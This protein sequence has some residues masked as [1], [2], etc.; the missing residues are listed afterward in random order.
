MHAPSMLSFLV[1][2]ILQTSTPPLVQM[3]TKPAASSSADRPVEKFALSSD[4]HEVEAPVTPKLEPSLLSIVLESCSIKSHESLKD[5]AASSTTTADDHV[6]EHGRTATKALAPLLDLVSKTPPPPL[7]PVPLALVTPVTAV[8]KNPPW[9]GVLGLGAAN[10]VMACVLT[11]LFE[12]L[13]TI[14]AVALLCMSVLGWEAQGARERRAL[15]QAIVASHTCARTVLD[16][17][18]QTCTRL[19]ESEGLIETVQAELAVAK[20]RY[21]EALQLRTELAQSKQETS[22]AKAPA[23][24]KYAAALEAASKAKAAT[25]P[26]QLR[27]LWRELAEEKAARQR[28]EE[29]AAEAEARAGASIMEAERLAARAKDAAASALRSSRNSGESDRRLREAAASAADEAAASKCTLCA[30]REDS[31]GAAEAEA[32][33]SGEVRRL[34]L[35]AA[36]ARVDEK[37]E[38]MATVASPA[39]PNSTTTRAPVVC[40]L[41][42]PAPPPH[43]PGAPGASV[44]DWR[45]IA[46]AEV[47]ALRHSTET[48]SSAASFMRAGASRCEPVHEL[49]TAAPSLEQ[50][51]AQA[52]AERILE[53]SL[54]AARRLK[55]R[56]LALGLSS[57]S[58][59]GL[60]ASEVRRRLRVCM[61]CTQR[62]VG[63]RGVSVRWALGQWRLCTYRRLQ[64]LGQ[65]K[66]S[67]VLKQARQSQEREEF[68]AKA[69]WDAEDS[70]DAVAADYAHSRAACV[71]ARAREAKAEMAAEAAA[72]RAAA[73]ERTIQ[74]LLIQL[75]AAEAAA[76]AEASLLRVKHELG[77]SAELAQ[78]SARSVEVARELANERTQRA[79]LETMLGAQREEVHSA[80]VAAQEARAQAAEWQ[81]LHAQLQV[82]LQSLPR[83][84]QRAIFVAMS[85]VARSS[86]STDA[87]V[88]VSVHAS[89]DEDSSAKPPEMHRV[90]AAAAPL[91]GTLERSTSMGTP[92]TG[93]R[94]PQLRISPSSEEWIDVQDACERKLRWARTQPEPHS[95]PLVAPASDAHSPEHALLPPPEGLLT[96]LLPV[97]KE[98]L[99]SVSPA[100][101]KR[102]LEKKMALQDRPCPSRQAISRQSLKQPLPLLPAASRLE[103]RDERL[104][105][106][107]AS[108]VSPNPRTRMAT[109]SSLRNSPPK[110][111][112]TAMRAD[113]EPSPPA[114]TPGKPLTS[115]STPMVHAARAAALA[116]ASWMPPGSKEPMCVLGSL[117][118][119]QGTY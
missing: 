47:R 28:S 106:R 76:E 60:R 1:V 31:V 93:P 43:T 69:R 63:R 46:T 117:L 12:G 67:D 54:R 102:M 74:V 77:M 68:E 100:Q 13:G 41:L 80:Q 82:A 6:Q 109:R 32:Q 78:A 4:E 45:A 87:S 14:L 24:T 75:Q 26:P 50:L 5:E 52:H 103:R 10:A 119:G 9:L 7:P 111:A 29:R 114:A 38:R 8:P 27:E 22:K 79:V 95:E 20:E 96:S 98:M 48:V 84:L 91:M 104:G 101:W 88:D 30:A 25:M 17:Y 57:W 64:A 99:H 86:S 2:N 81:Q 42:P 92:L 83:D 89:A 59:H 110:P 53:L 70:R 3:Y 105:S 113:S 39:D 61:A 85:Q 58:A 34:K 36:T 37:D 15:R 11:S 97:G 62:L 55:Y 21:T 65:Q 94:P 56:R 49:P 107:R 19:A 90:A 71:A 16:A 51:G 115:T 108:S 23:D 40:A 116:A 35:A 72:L 118:P 112:A 73:A 66:C 33:R 44:V 18:R